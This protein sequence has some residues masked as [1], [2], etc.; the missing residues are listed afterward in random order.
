MRSD[1]VRLS[2]DAVRTSAAHITPAELDQCH[3][4]KY[5]DSTLQ[6]ERDSDQLVLMST[7]IVKVTFCDEV[8]SYSFDLSFN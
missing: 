2:T 3:R 1:A 4:D 5:V 7:S 8:S 6:V